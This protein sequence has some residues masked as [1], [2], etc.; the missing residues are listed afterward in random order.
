MISEQEGT[1]SGVPFFFFRDC[2]NFNLFES[3]CTFQFKAEKSLLAPMRESTFIART[4][5]F[6]QR[7]L[8]S[9]DRGA[10]TPRS[11]APGGAACGRKVLHYVDPM[12]PA[13][14]SDKP[15][16]APCGM[17]MEPVYADVGLTPPRQR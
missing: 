17:P 3:L 13:H 2:E 16:N 15:G 9:R 8:S 10:H 1:L 5:W 6:S 12:N 7:G 4:C 14:T 11:L